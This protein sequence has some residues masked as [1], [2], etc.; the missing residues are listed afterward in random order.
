MTSE[1]TLTRR[2]FVKAGGALFVGIAVFP[3]LSVGAARATGAAATTL[4]PTAV[5]SWLEIHEDG[6]I[7]ARTGKTETGTSASAFYAQA[8]AD[9]LDVD[10]AKITMVMGHT[11]E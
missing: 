1:L 6:T 5:A 9:E 11:D 8:I 7:I 3:E 10:P 2:C 4:D